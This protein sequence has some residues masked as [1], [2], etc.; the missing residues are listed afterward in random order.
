M[1]Y[2]YPAVW[3]DGRQANSRILKD[4]EGYKLRFKGKE[5]KKSYYVCRMRR[6]KG[7]PVKVSLDHENDLILEKKGEH[8][9]DNELLREEVRS[10]VQ[11]K[12]EIVADLPY[13]SPRSVLQDVTRNVLSDENTRGGL[14]Y[15]PKPKSFAKA[16]QRKRKSV[17][18][19]PALPS[20]FEEFEVPEKFKLTSDGKP[21]LICE[22]ELENKAGKV[23]GFSSPTLLNELKI[24]QEWFVDGTWDIVR[25]TFFTQAW[26]IVARTKHAVSIPCAFFLLPDKKPASYQIALDA[27]K[28]QGVP[29]PQIVH[30]DFEKAEIKAFN[31]EYSDSEIVT[32]FVHWDR[33]IRKKLSD[34]KLV[35]YVN[36]D[37]RIQQFFKKVKSLCFVPLEDVAKIWN[38]LI[39][40]DVPIMDE[41]D[42]EMD[43][44]IVNIFNQAMGSFKVYFE[45][46][47]VGSKKGKKTLKPMYKLELWNKRQAA[48]DEEEVT[49]NSSE[50]WNSVSK[51]GLPLKPN[52]WNVLAAISKEDSFARSKVLKCAAGQWTD[53]N[54]GRTQRYEDRKV[55][56]KDAVSS[57]SDMLLE[58]WLDMV[59][60]F[61]D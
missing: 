34:L 3:I 37:I 59:V 29:G 30:L 17:L 11:D 15:L 39:E 1:R 60:S 32:C 9:H 7:C 20:S 25:D 27:L 61:F 55:Q 28:S 36:R 57:Y 41:E 23:I 14:V 51:A 5:G 52:V 19:C 43:E 42:E 33:A 18:D 54:P 2:P 45:G 48:L 31:E 8:N 58:D 24:S 53:P 22:K 35:P 49:S 16:L 46:T 6:E 10:K 26:V 56:L 44:D 13:T 38:F 50:S 4:P 21:F 12:L 40:E 47:W